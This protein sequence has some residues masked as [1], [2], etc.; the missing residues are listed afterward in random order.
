MDEL[1]SGP[2]AGSMVGTFRLVREG[3]VSFYE[4]FALEEEHGTVALRVKHFNPGPGL[5]GWEE[6]EQ[7]VAFPL[8][9]LEGRTAWFN[10]LTY[11]LEGPDT[12]VIYLALRSGEGPVRE[13]AFR[14]V[15]VPG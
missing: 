5:P 11:R 4:L 1:W 7:D 3:Q 13:E 2:A 10:G 6:R 9:K 14:L 12:L 15:R 8:V